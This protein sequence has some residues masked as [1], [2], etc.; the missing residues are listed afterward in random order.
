METEKIP[1]IFL[2]GFMGVGK[3]TISTCLSKISKRKEIDTDKMIA[4]EEGMTI[5]ELF[6]KRGEAYFRSCETK[7]LERLKQEEGFLVS[8]GGGMAMREQNAVL[9]KES[10]IVVLLTASPATI[11]ERVRHSQERPILNGNMN[12]EFIAELMGKRRK[13]YEAAADIIVKTDDRDVEEIC[14]D[15]MKQTKNL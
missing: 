12:V 3:S 10:G 9:M 15:I 14:E 6:E 13:K 2:I 7:L 5:P 4:V 8:C 1:H 11:F